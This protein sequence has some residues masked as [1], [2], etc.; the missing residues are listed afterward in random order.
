MS[1]Q[2]VRYPAVAG[3][4][5]PASE[6]QLSSAIDTF[7]ANAEP[8]HVRPK[9]LIVPH[10]GYM[11]SGPIAA[12]AYR[13]LAELSPKPTRVVLL[14][15][16]HH[17]GFPGL[18]LPG[19]DAFETPLGRVRIDSAAVENLKILPFVVELPRAHEKEHSLEVQVP[20]LQR[21]LGAFTLVPLSV[22]AASPEEVAEAL[23]VLWGGD[24]TLIVISTDLSHYLPYEEAKRIDGKTTQAIVALNEARLTGDQACGFHPLR[25]LLR[26]ARRHGLK[27]TVLDVR[28]SGDTA[29]PSGQVVGYGAFAL[30]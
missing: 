14:G 18:A 24:E 12:S 1:T 19:V 9:A 30:A 23:D 17:V 27:V 28:S 26:S 25:G 5:Y 8:A 15:P 16:S 11:Y 22:G 20:F 3:V 13:Q 10:A 6:A 4:F 29:G 7:M 21:V 2:T